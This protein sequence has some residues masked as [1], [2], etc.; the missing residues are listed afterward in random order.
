MKTLTSL[1]LVLICQTVFAQKNCGTSSYLDRVRAE[2]SATSFRNNLSFAAPQ[3][4]NSGTSSSELSSQTVINIPVV[5]HVLYNANANVTDEQIKSQIEALNRNFNKENEDFSKVPDVFASLAGVANIRFVLA[6]VDP[7]GRATNGI[8]RTKSSRELWSNDDKMK[9]P[10]YGGVAPWDSKSY[11]NIWVCN[12]VPGLLGY[13]SAP[14]SPADKDGVVIKYNIFGTTAAGNFN[15]GRTAV[16]EVGHWLN[17]KHLWG[18]KECGSDEVDDTPQQRTYNQ[19]TPTFPKMGMG[20]SASN[21]YGEMFMNF[22]DFTNDASMMMFTNGQVKRMRDL[23]NAGGI[24][25]SVRFS[26]A[27]GEPWNN[28]PVAT[29][30]SGINTG[31]VAEPAPLV[32][33]AAVKLYPNPAVEKITLSTTNENSITG[34]TY[35]VYAADGRIVTTGTISSNVF[36]L[37]ISSLHRGIYFIRIGENADKQVLRF[38]KQ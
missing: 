34:K 15:M 37:N 8:T 25:E 7:D 28:S 6:K 5:V 2:Y 27:L 16:H 31:T 9:M 14:G 29:N 33:I 17:L 10:S 20:C 22:M 26:K 38:V 18:D 23:F 24:R 35:A 1:V 21:P 12:L 3:S 32:V 11:L 30:N 36:N 4:S 13:S 19:G